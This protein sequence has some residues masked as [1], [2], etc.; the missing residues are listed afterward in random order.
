M[1]GWEAIKNPLSNRFFTIGWGKIISYCKEEKSL[2]H[3]LFWESAGYTEGIMNISG[4]GS[5]KR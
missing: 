1:D 2:G 5:V 3:G 4:A